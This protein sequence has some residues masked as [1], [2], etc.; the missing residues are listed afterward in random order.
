M[1]ALQDCM[2]CLSTQLEMRIQVSLD[3]PKIQQLEILI[4]SGM[5]H[6]RAEIQ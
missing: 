4:L 5:E 6:T 3:Q 2:D 1:E